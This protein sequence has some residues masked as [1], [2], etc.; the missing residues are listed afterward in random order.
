MKSAVT[1]L[2]VAFLAMLT[3]L[4]AGCETTPYEYSL[5][6][7]IS[8]TMA[9]FSLTIATNEVSHYHFSPG[10]AQTFSQEGSW[11]KDS[12][13]RYILFRGVNIGSQ[14]KFAPLYLPLQVSSFSDVKTELE[15][16]SNSLTTL[17]QLGFNFV[18]LVIM[19]KGLE[20]TPDDGLSKS[21]LKA[22]GEI[23]DALYQQ[24][25][26]VLI[27]FHQDI[28]SDHYGGDGFPDWA[29]SV[30]SEFPYSHL[31]PAPNEHWQICYTAPPFSYLLGI[32][33]RRCADVTNTL[34]SFWKNNTTNAWWNLQNF[35]AQSRLISAVT[36]TAAFFRGNPAIIGFEPFNEPNS[37]GLGKRQ[38]EENYL[39]PFY[40]Q[41]D[42]SLQTVDADRFLFIEPRTD[43]TIF[44][45]DLPEEMGWN[46]FADTLLNRF[47][48]K[49]EQVRSYLG[50]GSTNT[51]LA[52]GAADGGNNHLV[53][54]FHYYDPNTIKKAEAP[55]F[56]GG[57]ADSMKGREMEWPGLFDAMIYGATNRGMI[58]FMTEFGAD[59]SWS[60]YSTD[61]GENVYHNEE[62]AYLDLGFQEIEKHC[63]N[64]SL[65]VYDFYTPST[66]EWN[67]EK[68]SLRRGYSAL[69]SE[70]GKKRA[71]SIRNPDIIAR[72]YPMRSSAKP[73]LLNF[74]VGS[75]QAVI[76]LKGNPVKAPTVIYIPKDIQY[77]HQFEIHASSKQLAWDDK[78]QLLYWL[79]DTNESLHE[80]IIAPKGQFKPQLLPDEAKLVRTAYTDVV[81]VRY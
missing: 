49:P 46:A 37:V 15:A 77:P 3:A 36:Q 5:P 34:Q 22:I 52:P 41:I 12:E 66:E 16:N 64:S 45:A 73:F 30:N 70:P 50:L 24:G 32:P 69:K 11:F 21:Y 68:L 13:G 53:F 26:F 2:R 56:L 54:S 9:P 80:I 40:R 78:K 76:M 71:W 72:P 61:L 20:P 17:N 44:P 31:P 23:I 60:R 65:W 6:I 4:L 19:W 42:A 29:I 1:I 58:P 62:R 48:S 33:E 14:S 27:D 51:F 75:T 81:P 59:A 18:R 43:W 8:H 10:V 63:L 67:G 39:T 28:A 55:W 47:V 57:G 74:D 79:P 38:F 35:P 25:I 7:P